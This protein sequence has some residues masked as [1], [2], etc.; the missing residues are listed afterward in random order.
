MALGQLTEFKSLMEQGR[1][2][3]KNQRQLRIFF[4]T[5]RMSC[6]LARGH[7]GMPID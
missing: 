5:C 4:V 3:R 2:S 1:F 6:V 7:W